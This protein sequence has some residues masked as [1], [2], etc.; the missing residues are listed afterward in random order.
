MFWQKL[1]EGLGRNFIDLSVPRHFSLV[2]LTALFSHFAIRTVT[3][4]QSHFLLFGLTVRL[5]TGHIELQRDWRLLQDNS[6]LEEA[7][8][9]FVYARLAS[10]TKQVYSHFS[11]QVSSKSKAG[12][13]RL[14]NFTS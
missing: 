6:Y 5:L 12:D 14:R 11:L 3:R 1:H 8:L 9:L 13:N 2:R 7:A 4:D 10:I